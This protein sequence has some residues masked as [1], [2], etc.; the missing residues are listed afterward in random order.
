MATVDL[1]RRRI[2]VVEDDYLLAAG[3]VDEIEDHNG[4]AIGPAPTLV[5]GIDLLR[6][7]RPDACILNIRLGPNMVY[8]L[9]DE[10]LTAGI[11]FVFA[12]AE[13]RSSIPHRFRNIP[14]HT[15]PV[16]MVRAAATLMGPG[17]QA[18]E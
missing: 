7:E 4:I 15:K 18:G 6:R 13:H 10:I 16:D 2:L 11:P 8:P 5:T 17:A 9:A 12:S 3:I 14:L 1:C